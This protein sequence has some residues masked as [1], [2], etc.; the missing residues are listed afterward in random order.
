MVTKSAKKSNQEGYLVIPENDIYVEIKKK[1]Y[2]KGDLIFPSKEV[3]KLIRSIDKYLSFL[4]E[5]YFDEIIDSDRKDN[6]TDEIL[7]KVEESIEKLNN[8]N[9]WF[10][11]NIYEENIHFLFLI[12]LKGF[13][14][15]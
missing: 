15:F 3:Y 2:E 7:A 13:I 5:D 8:I 6:E 12:N 14:I 9:D 11:N 4:D 1:N 10:F